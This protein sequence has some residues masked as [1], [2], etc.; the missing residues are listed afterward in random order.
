MR[1]TL[2]AQLRT[3][4][5]GPLTLVVAPAGFGKTTLLSHWGR[6]H[7]PVG[8]LSLDDGDNA[9]CVCSDNLELIGE[10]PMIDPTSYPVSNWIITPA[11]PSSIWS[12]W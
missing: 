2:V 8:W 3:A 1:P 10:R 11:G 5:A 12:A 7:E 6:N 4:V 9:R